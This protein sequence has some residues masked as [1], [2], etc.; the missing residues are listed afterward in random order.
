MYVSVALIL[1]GWAISF[2][3]GALLAYALLV[4]LAFHLR[5]VLA[6]EPYLARTHGEAWREYAARVP[7]W[8]W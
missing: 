7:R 1:L 4:G 2:G 6:E 8:L 5:V 3:S